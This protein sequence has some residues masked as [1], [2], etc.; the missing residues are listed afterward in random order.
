MSPPDE[1]PDPHG[2]TAYCCLLHVTDTS[3]FNC[4]MAHNPADALSLSAYALHADA[5]AVWNN[6]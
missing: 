4:E 6:P 1:T 5:G 2:R 3:Q